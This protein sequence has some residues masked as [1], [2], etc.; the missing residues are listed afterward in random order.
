MIKIPFRTRLRLF[1][2]LTIS[3]FGLFILSCREKADKK[4][5][6]EVKGFDT[7]VQGQAIQMPTTMPEAAPAAAQGPAEKIGWSLP[8][9]WNA[10]VGSGM[11][12]AVL[13]TS[14]KPDADEGGIVVLPGEAGGLQANVQRWLGQLSISL[15]ANGMEEFI[16]K[17]KKIKSK[18]NLDL[19]LLDF[20]P[21]A[22][23][24]DSRSMLIAI[25]KPGE[26]SYFIKLNGTKENLT[27]EKNDFVKFCESLVLE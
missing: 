5:F 8:Q 16:A 4:T 7:P 15:P 21:L 17:Q 11:Y 22:A 23:G 27:K 26:N 20:N 9:G 14:S 24:N 19:L 2:L 3:V 1:F 13:K 6:S 12:Y 18:G 25:T 10:H